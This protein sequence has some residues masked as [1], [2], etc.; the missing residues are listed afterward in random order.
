MVWLMKGMVSCVVCFLPLSAY[1]FIDLSKESENLMDKALIL[2]SVVELAEEVNVHAETVEQISNLSEEIRD[3]RRILR[4][5]EWTADEIDYVVNPQ[6]KSYE[7]IYRNIRALTRYIRRTKNLAKKLGV[8]P[9]ASASAVAAS[10]QMQTNAVLNEMLSQRYR[11]T[12]QRE[13]EKMQKLRDQIAHYK[14]EQEFVKTQYDYI[15]RHSKNNGFGYYHPYSIA[16]VS[17]K[18]GYI[19]RTRDFVSSGLGRSFDFI[20][21]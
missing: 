15:N 20:G 14:K 11:E 10:E 12:A 2:D 17:R 6:M 3:I 5:I 7:Q 19:E 1:C 8:Y 9:K 18:K 21:F 16:D 4:E 13:Q